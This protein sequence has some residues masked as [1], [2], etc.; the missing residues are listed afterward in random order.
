MS[1]D[2]LI[3]NIASDASMAYADSQN[4]D[5]MKKMAKGGAQNLEAV[6][7]KFESV[8]LGFLIKQMWESVDKS[9]LLPESGGQQIQDGML[10]TMLADYLS[11]NGGIGIAK[12]MVR[13]MKEVAEAYEKQKVSNDS[14]KADSGIQPW[15]AGAGQGEAAPLEEN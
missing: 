15:K 10:T 9:E 5:A 1:I 2:P 14:G 13:Q 4:V 8:F 3:S 6:A 12:S 7:E 11:Q